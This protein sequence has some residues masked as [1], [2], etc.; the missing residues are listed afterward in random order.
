MTGNH[1]SAADERHIAGE[2]EK[3]LRAFD[4]DVALGEN[5]FLASRIQAEM[6]SRVISRTEGFRLRFNL[7]YAIVLLVLL[8]NLIT[9]V[10]FVDWSS[11]NNLHE[12]LVTEL[13]DDFDIDQ[14]QSAF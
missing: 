1:M 8:I 13:E 6:N 7:R 4:N 9:I 10:H 14:N 11:T 3:T 5:P 12:K 2:V